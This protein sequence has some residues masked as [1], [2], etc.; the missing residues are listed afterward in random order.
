LS[1]PRQ[2]APPGSLLASWT[3]FTC[4]TF[5]VTFV[6]YALLGH[7]RA[8]LGLHENDL[9]FG[10]ALL[11]LCGIAGSL[12]AG[13]WIDRR[14]TSPPRLMRATAVLSAL[15]IVCAW[16]AM[17]VG[18]RL[19]LI[20]LFAP[21]G[22]L[23]GVTIVVLLYQFLILTPRNLRGVFAGLIAGLVYLTANI[24][25]CYAGSPQAIGLVDLALLLSNVLLIYRY[26]RLVPNVAAVALGIETTRAR[27]LRSLWPLALIVLADTALFVHVSRATGVQAVFSGRGDWLTNGICHFVFAVAAGLIYR[28]WGWRRI[29]ALA[30]YVLALTIVLFLFQQLG[31]AIF[32]AGII[33][34]YSLTVGAYTVAL[35]TVFGEETPREKPASGVAL[36]MVLIGWI[37]S[38]AGLTLGAA[39][40]R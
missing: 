34:L 29:T 1:E 15:L 10:F 40:L 16:A 36:G 8:E 12:F 35:F 21:L 26:A 14:R 6:Q 2:P 11:A 25:A 30:G 38:P 24:Q 23:L 33:V 7:A 4:F 32:A 22:V 37:A 31:H 18:G 27:M 19:A 5:Y 3:L 20:V 28:R 13:W 17:R 9:A 39:L